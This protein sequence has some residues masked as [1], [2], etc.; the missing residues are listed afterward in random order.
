MIVVVDTEMAEA[1][2]TSGIGA[3]SLADAARGVLEAAAASAGPVAL[4]AVAQV[5]V[6]QAAGPGPQPRGL[7]DDR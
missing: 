4:G 5:D 3:L 1:L 6:A 7:P 2:A